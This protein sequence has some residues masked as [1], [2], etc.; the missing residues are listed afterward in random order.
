MQPTYRTLGR[1][2]LKVSP[3][4]LGSMMFGGPTDEPTAHR[5]I[6]RAK[7]EGVNFLDTAD[8]YEKG[9]T[10]EVVGRALR[11]GRD[12]WVLATK[13]A[14]A[15]GPGANEGG[16]SRKWIHQALEGSLRRLGTDYVDILYVHRLT[17]DPRLDEAV[18]ALGDLIRA[19]KIRY[20]GVSNFRG[21]RIAEVVRLA[22]RAG[23]DPPV[24][25]Q[26]LYNIVSRGAELEQLPAAVNCGLGIVPYS[27]LARGVLTAKYVPGAEPPPDTRAGRND[28]R[29]LETEWRPESIEVARRVAERA[30]SHGASA[31]EF[32]IAWVLANRLVT[33]VI[34]GPRTEE[35]WASYGAAL[36]LRLTAEDEAFV[37]A[38][39]SPGHASTHGFNDPAYPPEGRVTL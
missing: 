13:F 21:F 14:N 9:R 38:L 36:R 3:L 29:I 12:G 34:A 5:I 30:A 15:M 6:A 16:L 17:P 26:P 18:R 28:K 4:C 20:W 25:S 24:V 1:S 2:A 39:V 33:S 35:Q 37:D 7:D 23:V 31:T 32:A 8:V 11:Q 22:E 27:P 10:E 19:G